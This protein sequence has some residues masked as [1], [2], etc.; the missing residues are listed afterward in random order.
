[1]KTPFFFILL[2]FLAICGMASEANAQT[3]YREDKKNVGY[4]IGTTALQK[5]SFHGAAVVAQRAS[6][7]Q[8]AVPATPIDDAAGDAPT[9]A[10]YNA[11]VARINALT[12]LVNELRAA[13]VEKG[14]IKGAAG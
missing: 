8:A 13:L 4:Q 14:L 2:I 5:I 11:A 10:E 7:A 9:A 6:A 1:M 12:V 3:K